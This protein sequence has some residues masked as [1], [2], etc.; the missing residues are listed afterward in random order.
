[1]TETF[2]NVTL[3]A[4]AAGVPVVAARAT[5][6]VGLVDDGV[7]GVLVEPRN[8]SGYADAIEKLV[9]DHDAR[10]TMGIMGSR[11]AAGY[12]WDTINEG[13]LTTYLAL[14]NER[15]KSLETR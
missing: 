10:R 8:I 14:M 9:L 7:T 5:G 1:M 4:M 6:A 12:R 2:G 11:K 13:V 15:D 3:E